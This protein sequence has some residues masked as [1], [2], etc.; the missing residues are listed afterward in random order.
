MKTKLINPHVP[1]CTAVKQVENGIWGSA[2]FLN[3]YTLK[4]IKLDN[5]GRKTQAKAIGRKWVKLIC[6]SQ[7]CNAEVLIQVEEIENHVEHLL[8]GVPT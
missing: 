3:V 1:G 5:I 6:N 8:K 4:P 2:W 7:A